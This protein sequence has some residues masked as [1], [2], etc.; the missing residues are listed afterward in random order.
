M[1]DSVTLSEIALQHELGWPDFHPEDYC[2][3]CGHRNVS[4]HA[5]SPLW[6]AVM[7]YPNERWNGIVCMTCFVQ[8]ATERG[9]EARWRLAFVGVEDAGLPAVRSDGY[10]YDW[11]TDLWRAPSGTVGTDNQEQP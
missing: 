8:L 5:P 7:D 9:I 11:G 2:H 1:T 4:W 6:N 10:V 3:R